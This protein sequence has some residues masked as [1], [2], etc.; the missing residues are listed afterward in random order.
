MS[1][2]GPE[3]N[4][5]FSNAIYWETSW[6][7]ELDLHEVATR[8]LVLVIPMLLA[9]SFWFFCFVLFSFSSI[10]PHNPPRPS[11][12]TPFPRDIGQAG[13]RLHPTRLETW[14][15]GRWDTDSEGRSYLSLK[16]IIFFFFLHVAQEFHISRLMRGKSWSS[17]GTF[18]S[19]LIGTKLLGDELGD[20]LISVNSEAGGAVFSHSFFGDP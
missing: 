9:L 1:V 3:P 16:L 4:V 14:P 11:G 18:F 10:S 15:G 5:H 2:L 17:P 13:L 19:F 12:I 7:T 6:L 20:A 8:Y